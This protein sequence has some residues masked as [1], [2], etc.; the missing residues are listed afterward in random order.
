[1]PETYD[2]HESLLGA[3]EAAFLG[4]MVKPG[5]GSATSKD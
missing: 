1:M 3:T 5:A 4:G 2:F